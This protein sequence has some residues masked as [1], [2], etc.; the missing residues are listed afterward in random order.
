MTAADQQ[1][2]RRLHQRAAAIERQ[3]FRPCHDDQVIGF[4]QLGDKRG[5]QVIER[6]GC[7]PDFVANGFARKFIHACRAGVRHQD[8]S[9]AIMRGLNAQPPDRS[10]FFKVAGDH[11]HRVTLAKRAQV[12]PL[13]HTDLREK[14]HAAVCWGPGTQPCIFT[15]QLTKYPQVFVRHL[16]AGNRRNFP[17]ALERIRYCAQCFAPARRTLAAASSAEQR[18]HQAFF[19]AGEVMPEAPLVT[20]PDFVDFF[21]LARHHTLDHRPPVEFTVKTSA[22]RGVAANRAVRADA[23]HVGQFP[24]ARAEAEIGGCQRAYRADVSRIAGEI[25]VERRVAYGDNL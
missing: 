6:G 3:P 23:R 19:A 14:F 18:L 2:R 8:E 16:R 13:A 5:I 24:R 9:A 4:L 10:F 7:L 1:V 22:Q 15:D 11:Q 25:A 17:A 20:N 12:R 21:V